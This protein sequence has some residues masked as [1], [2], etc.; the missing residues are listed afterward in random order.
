MSHALANYDGVEGKDKWERASPVGSFFPN[1]LGLCDMCCNVW[2]WCSSLEEPY[3]YKADDGREDP[4]GKEPRVLRGG[5][6][7]GNPRVARCAYRYESNPGSR[8]DSIGFRLCASPF[9]SL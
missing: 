6:F 5:A 8:Y 4:Q 3:P 9:Q 1:P 7:Y 2:E